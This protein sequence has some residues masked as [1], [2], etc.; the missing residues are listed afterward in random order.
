MEQHTLIQ[1]VNRMNFLHKMNI[2]FH[3]IFSV[4][5]VMTIITGIIYY[6]SKCGYLIHMP[7]WLLISSA[8]T[9]VTFIQGYIKDLGEYFDS[10]NILRYFVFSFNV[11]WSVLGVITLCNIHCIDNFTLLYMMTL[12]LV[13]FQWTFII[14]QVINVYYHNQF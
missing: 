9:L 12:L 4:L 1:N 11:I 7:L 5:I 6:D 3:V 13:F 14:Y 8:I 2:L 10:T